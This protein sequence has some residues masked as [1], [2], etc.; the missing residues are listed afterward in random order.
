MA[1]PRIGYPGELLNRS[2]FDNDPSITTRLQ[3]CRVPDNP[4]AARRII[5][6][7]DEAWRKAWAAELSPAKPE[8]MERSEWQEGERVP[9][10]DGVYEV[11]WDNKSWREPGQLRESTGLSVTF[12]KW[13]GGQWTAGYE[14]VDAADRAIGRAV[15]WP[16]R[17][18]GISEAQ[19]RALGVIQRCS[20]C[21]GTGEDF[22][23]GDPCHVCRGAGA[24]GE[25]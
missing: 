14:T 15:C 10:A 19:A 9:W 20:A 1:E 12:A 22:N 16:G 11:E 7:V 4:G 23:E 17:W 6:A 13:A 18:R 5:L 25:L 2:K 8:D 21:A 3:Y 24:R